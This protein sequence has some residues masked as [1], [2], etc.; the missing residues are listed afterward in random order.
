[1]VEAV[2]QKKSE[3]EQTAGPQ[4]REFAKDAKESDTGD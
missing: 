3:E 4:A 2:V 1:M